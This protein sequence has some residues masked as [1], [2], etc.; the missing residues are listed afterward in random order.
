[1]KQHEVIQKVFSNT[2]VEISFS[3]GHGCHNRA[4][5][6]SQDSR[7]SVKV[8]HSAGIMET[9]RPLQCRLL[10]KVE[11]IEKDLKI[12]VKC[13]NFIYIFYSLKYIKA[14]GVT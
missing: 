13:L 11:F 12:F 1:M 4:D 10:V 9:D 6:S 3:G 7:H 5:A 8:V 2:P 14:Y